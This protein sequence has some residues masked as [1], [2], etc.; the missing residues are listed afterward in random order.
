MKYFHQKNA[1]NK[2]VLFCLKETVFF[3]FFLFSDAIVPFCL[4]RLLSTRGRFLPL[5]YHKKNT[6]V[7]LVKKLSRA[8][9]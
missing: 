6:A 5:V 7:P 3:S 8:I 9:G 1:Q 2:G 4:Q